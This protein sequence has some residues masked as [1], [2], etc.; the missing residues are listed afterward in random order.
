MATYKAEFRAHYSDGRL[1]PRAAYSMGMI[2][3][4]SRAARLMPGFANLLTQTPGLSAVVKYAGGLAQER[5]MPAYPRET[6]GDWF[7]RH[8]G[9]NP[10]GPE[11]MLF[12][13]T[14][15][16]FLRPETAIAAVNALE[17]AG[18]RV[19]VPSRT[20]CCARPL[21]DWRMLAQADRLLRQLLDA[22]APALARGV[23]IVGLEPACVAAFRDEVTA[24]FPDDERARQ[25]KRQSCLFGEFIEQRC[26]EVELPQPG[27]ARTALIQIHC[28]EHA[29]LDQQPATLGSRPPRWAPA[30]PVDAR[31]S[32][33]VDSL[34]GTA[35]HRR[36][37][38]SL[39]KI[40]AG[41]S[42]PRDRKRDGRRYRVE[43]SHHLECR[44]LGETRLSG[45]LA[46]LV[47]GF[48]RGVAGRGLRDRRGRA[49][50]VLQRGRGKI[51]RSDP[52]TRQRPVVRHL[53]PAVA[54]R[55]ADGA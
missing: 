40:E 17:A 49:N 12:P 7:R 14:F 44:R 3:W 23:P 29:V 21:Y 13:D 38:P 33:P 24:L 43:G 45:R 48:S 54:G 52:R 1:R 9:R 41:P 8:R 19:T 46:N 32:D 35:E 28:H 55:A 5:R 10:A 37:F 4:W 30:P 26:R 50:H 16:N 53:A 51:V 20:L 11:V 42:W 18:W 22:L 47:S 31:K 39:G 25:L 15:N 36:L 2:Y 27:G 34:S 6:F